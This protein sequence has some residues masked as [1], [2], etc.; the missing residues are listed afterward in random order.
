MNIVKEQGIWSD[1]DLVLLSLGMFCIGLLLGS[2][3]F[4]ITNALQIFFI[5]I[6]V[7]SFFKPFIVWSKTPWKHPEKHVPKQNSFSSPNE[8]K[9]SDFTSSLTNLKSM[10]SKKTEQQHVQGSVDDFLNE[11][12]TSNTSNNTSNALPQQKTIPSQ[13]LT[14]PKKAP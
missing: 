1:S 6:A 8:N 14:P 4:H 13:N 5:L 12:I 10:F 3:L 2:Y 9:K 7:V 11:E